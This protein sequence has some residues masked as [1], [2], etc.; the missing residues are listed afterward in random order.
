M[1]EEWK[2]ALL[3]ISTRSSEM[4]NKKVQAEEK[5]E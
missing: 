2:G 4:S 1:E 3:V 5:E